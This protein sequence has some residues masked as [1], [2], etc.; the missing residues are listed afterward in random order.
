M[1]FTIKAAAVCGLLLLLFWINREFLDMEPD[2][3]QPF[4]SSFGLLAPFVFLLLFSIRPFFLFPASILAL[5]SGLA[6]G[7]FLGPI[8]TYAGSLS[9]AVLSY[10]A[11]RFFRRNHEIPDHSG[12]RRVIQQ[13]IEENGF[14]YLVSLRIIPVIHFDLVTYLSAMARV[15]FRTFLYATMAGIIPGT[16]AFNLLGASI[17]DVSIPLAAATVLMFLIALSIPWIVKRQLEKRNISTDEW[18]ES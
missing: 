8:L 14:F 11:V 6:F 5:T 15:R 13:R 18:K 4:I 2:D 7:P 16:L 3:I 9:G 10:W 17:A 1:R 12:K